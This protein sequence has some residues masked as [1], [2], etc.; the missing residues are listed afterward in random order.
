MPPRELCVFHAQVTAAGEKGTEWVVVFVR[1]GGSRA[2]VV[3]VDSL[4]SSP[5]AR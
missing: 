1:T 4:R 3:G 5:K 2:R